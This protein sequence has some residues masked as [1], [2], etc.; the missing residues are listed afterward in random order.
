MPTYNRRAFVPRAIAYFLRQDYPNR[1]L[2]ILDDGSD[3]VG[4]LIPAD[5][6]IRYLHLEKRLHTGAKRNLACEQARGDLIMHWDDD[7]WY[8]PQRLRYQVEALLAADA[9]L[10]GLRQMLF[11]DLAGKKTWLYEYP[12]HQRLWLA[13]GSL[14]YTRQFWQRR[15]F[16]NLQVGEDTRFVWGQAPA[17]AIAL[18]TFDFYV[19]MIHPANTSPKQP[20]GAYWSR[21]AGD[22]HALMGADLDAY[23][24]P[25]QT[26]DNPSGESEVDRLE[27][28]AGENSARPPS[29][30]NAE[31]QASAIGLGKQWPSVTVSIPC[32]NASSTLQRAVR[33]ILD[34]TYPHLTLVVIN[35]GGQTPWK[36]LEDIHDPRLIRFDLPVNRGRYFADNVVLEATRDPYLL[37]QDADDWSAPHRLTT[38]LRAQREAHAVGAI[39]TH[40]RHEG[41]RPMSQGTLERFLNFDR[42]L[43]NRFEHRANHHGL[44]RTEA[45]R[46][47]GGYYGGF[48][49]GYDTL[50][51][52]LLLMI[53]R[54]AYVNEPLY[55]RFIHP[56]SLT[57]APGTGTHSQAR[58][59]TTRSL[60][61]MYANAF[62]VYCQYV[63]G[64][65]EWAELCAA[66]RQITSQH[67]SDREQEALQM[68]AERLRS[69]WD[70]QGRQ[71]AV[72]SE[73]A[74]ADAQ[75]SIRIVQQVAS[76]K[77]IVEDDRLPFPEWS[78]GR[79]FARQLTH[80]L[81]QT[82]P[83][84][85]LE[86]GS[87]SSTVV[88][89]AYAA[90]AQA[91]FTSLEHEPRYF[92]QTRHLL[93]QFGLE[94]AVDLR[95]APLQP[96]PCPDG[97]DYPWYATEL[98][99]S[100][101][102]VLLDGPPER[103]GRQAALFV[104]AAQLVKPWE[105]WL[106]D[107]QRPHEKNCVSLWK[108][109]L[110]FEQNYV[111]GNPVGFYSLRS[112][113]CPLILPD[114][115][116]ARTNADDALLGITML[117][118]GRL[119]LFKR[120]IR[121]LQHFAP[122]LLN[123]ATVITLVNGLDPDTYTYASQLPFIN[124]VFY[125]TRAVLPIGE[126]VSLLVNILLQAAQPQL[127]L[128]LEDDWEA[129]LP[130]ADWLQSAV[131]IMDT[132]PQVGQVRLRHSQEK[133]LP[134]HMVTKQ[135]IHWQAREGYLLAKSAHFTFNPSILR[136][137][138]AERIYPCRNELEAQQHFLAAGLATAQLLP[139]VFRHI[140]N[141]VASRRIALGR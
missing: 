23:H 91:A 119:D 11:Y 98:N 57:T 13:G 74:S 117:T 29:E 99:D 83:K 137:A 78:V 124:Q 60:G 100:F 107:G 132:Q 31:T 24:K 105:I 41:H 15:P 73:S 106:H 85:L 118:G 50:L 54:L 82:C 62:Q 127:L 79:A 22:L 86:V 47:V 88:L 125:H 133:V 43:S 75:T 89:A 48:R 16:P 42:P 49:I 84:H 128:H 27:I 12:A 70:G 8:A 120:T 58:K 21:W 37:I 139:G 5:E 68:E 17:R 80:H 59:E 102:F 7:D 140:G 90:Q 123:R 64:Q 67:I 2:L 18:P 134:Y 141:G 104:L 87:G 56:G 14:L 130:A 96:T 66:I 101:D 19:A 26:P 28:V 114:H 95:L 122:D 129:N 20:R 112:P 53:G 111:P 135:P 76:F 94:H 38:L 34:Q 81:E 52:N 115:A 46:A 121:S 71:A 32:F 77:H 55:H 92:Q 35:D 72:Y 108:Q 103:F 40:W 4:D 93:N 61:Q 44:Y 10:C 39:S 30:T 116:T 36:F 25:P 9:E 3:P 33:S 69:L 45:L 65:F 110:E 1:E 113:G 136:I 126:A 6:R 97:N 138:D 109:Y 63:D 131:K 51:L